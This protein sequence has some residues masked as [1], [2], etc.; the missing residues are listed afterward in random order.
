MVSEQLSIKRVDLV[1]VGLNATDT[2]IPLQGFPTLGSK[3]EYSERRTLLGGEISTAVVACARWGLRTRYVGRL[4]DDHAALLH[5]RAF[6]KAGVET[7][8]ITVEDASSPQSLILVDGSGE[9]T[10]LCHRD[11]RLTLRPEDLEG[12]WITSARVLLVD[13]YHTE[14]SVC[15][16]TWAREAGIPV[17]ADL[18]V[19]RPGINDLL[20]LVDYALASREFPGALTGEPDLKKALAILHDHFGCRIAGVTLGLNGVVT[21]DGERL[22]QRTAYRVSTVDTTGAGDLFHAGFVY[23]LLQGWPIERQLDYA[24][25]AAALNCTRAGARGCIGKVEEIGR[26]MEGESRYDVADV[27]SG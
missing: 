6:E 24:C 22:I 1:G 18:D 13:G 26:L 19:I 23:G 20:P 7:R 17:V 27:I 3:T 5:R 12:E 14:A 8:I 25:A 9:R 2:V 21:W 11:P 10:V 15:A 4:G 16:A